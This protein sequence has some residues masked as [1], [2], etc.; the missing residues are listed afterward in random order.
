MMIKS[1]L[2]IVIILTNLMNK[3]SFTSFLAETMNINKWTSVSHIGITDKECPLYPD[4]FSV[5]RKT[6]QLSRWHC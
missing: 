3:L 2:T 6:V 1:F 4:K 5:M